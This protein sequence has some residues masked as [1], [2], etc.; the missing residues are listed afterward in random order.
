LLGGGLLGGSFLGGGFLFCS[1]F[2]GGSFLGSGLFGSG[3]FSR[4]AFLFEPLLFFQFGQPTFFFQ[5]RL[6]LRGLGLAAGAFFFLALLAFLFQRDFRVGLRRQ[7]LFYGGRRRGRLGLGF[8][9]RRRGLRFRLGL[10]RRFRRGLGLGLGSGLRL[11]RGRVGGVAFG[12]ELDLHRARVCRPPVDAENQGNQQQDMHQDGQPQRLAV[13][14]RGGRDG[15][16]AVV[17]EKRRGHRRCSGGWRR[18]INA[19]AVPVRPRPGRRAGPGASRR[20]CAGRP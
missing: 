14:L 4:L 16:L 17:F 5:A 19:S 6:F 1:G 20:C 10:R 9:L 12:P 18:C 11:R 8:W 2:L 15:G 3:F 13:V 7:R